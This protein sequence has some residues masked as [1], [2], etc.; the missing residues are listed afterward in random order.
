MTQYNNEYREKLLNEN[1]S[2]WIYDTLYLFV[3]PPVSFLSLMGN[4]LAYSILSRPYFNH[5]PLYTYLRA[6][7]LNSS[8]Y[9][10]ITIMN[11]IWMPRRHL[12]LANSELAAYLQCYLKFPIIFSTYLYGCLL[13]IILAIDRLFE[14][15]NRK[16]KFKCFQ[17][18]RICII[19]LIG[20]RNLILFKLFSNKYKTYD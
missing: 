10:L 19:L 3:I 4:M 1:G 13:D 18:Y 17:P 20:K 11:V 5:K 9:D 12:D 15:T 14:L 2:I 6:I 7:C 16:H 8:V